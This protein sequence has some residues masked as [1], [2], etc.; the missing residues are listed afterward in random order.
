MFHSIK[1][2]IIGTVV[3]LGVEE[4]IG[5]AF[6]VFLDRV[7]DLPFAVLTSRNADRVVHHARLFAGDQALIAIEGV[8]EDPGHATVFQWDRISSVGTLPLLLSRE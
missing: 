8:A 5:I 4:A 2:P 1:R 3:R 7:V 6:R